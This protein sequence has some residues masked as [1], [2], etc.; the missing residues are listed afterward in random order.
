MRPVLKIVRKSKGGLGALIGFGIGGAFGI[1]V[2]IAW[3]RDPDSGTSGFFNYLL[4][5]SLLTLIFGAPPALL[6]WIIGEIA[7]RDKTIQIEGK[8]DSKI[9]KI[10][11][12]LR[13][14]ARVPDFQ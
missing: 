9:K 4:G 11:E 12:D 8:S 10:L 1:A 5:F 14:E 7:G 6:G 2:G 13:E 3:S